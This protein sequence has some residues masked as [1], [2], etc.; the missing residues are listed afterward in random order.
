M[1]GFDN[2]YK[3]I[4]K[5]R[6]FTKLYDKICL[7]HIDAV[8]NMKKRIIRQACIELLGCF[9]FIG[10]IIITCVYSKIA[11][12][13]I[14]PFTII[15]LLIIALFAIVI[16]LFTLLRAYLHT[17]HYKKDNEFYKYFNKAI[18]RDIVNSF[19][20]LA[21]DDNMKEWDY[22]ELERVFKPH[23]G[24][25][26]T[27]VDNHFY[28]AKNTI[29]FEVFTSK[30]NNDGNNGLWYSYSEINNNAYSE[31]SFS[32]KNE[33]ELEK[34]DP[35]IQIVLYAFKEYSF[36][37]DVKVVGNNLMI[38]I[39]TDNAFEPYSDNQALGTYDIHY[40][41][42]LIK[43]TKDFTIEL[44]KALSKDTYNV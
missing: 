37:Y 1:I 44:N 28:G 10:S 31:L 24:N 5:D 23:W 3:T 41:Y 16:T 38:S 35:R 36:K 29:G 2:W 33:L 43:F 30:D 39:E 21:Y 13:N 27:N 4:D 26:F 42:T 12:R 15:S 11:Q 6:K 14:E 18:L 25:C 32:N 22:S 34:L 20:G 9:L 17:S 8:D 7:N 40:Y 19:D